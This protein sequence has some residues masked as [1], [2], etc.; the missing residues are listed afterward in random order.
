MPMIDV[1]APAEAFGDKYG[2][3]RRRSSPQSWQGAL[4]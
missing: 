4:R 1:Y 3:P 2:L